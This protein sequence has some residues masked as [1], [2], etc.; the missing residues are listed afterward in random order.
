MKGTVSKIEDEPNVFHVSVLANNL[1]STPSFR[2]DGGAEI[3]LRVDGSFAGT[4]NRLPGIG[5]DFHLDWALSSSNPTLNPPNVEFGN[6]SLTFGTFLSSVLD[7]VLSSIQDS[8]AMLQP[9]LKFLGLEVPGL[10]DLSKLANQ[11]PV[12]ILDL[13]TEASKVAGLGPLP[14]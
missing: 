11:G 1:L 8:T 5:A 14:I 12:T 4:D 9:V 10:S 2:L 7:P 13:A 3:N 6:V